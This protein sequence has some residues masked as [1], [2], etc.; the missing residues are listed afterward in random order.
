[1]GGGGGGSTPASVP[2]ATSGLVV[3]RYPI[4]TV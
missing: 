3:I 4:G 2:L 1:M